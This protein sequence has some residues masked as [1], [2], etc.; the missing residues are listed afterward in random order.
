MTM[1]KLKNCFLIHSA[2]HPFY[3]ALFLF[4]FSFNLIGQEKSVSDS[5]KNDILAKYNGFETTPTNPLLQSKFDSLLIAL[6]IEQK[7]FFVTTEEPLFE[8]I[9]MIASNRNDYKAITIPNKPPSF[10]FNKTTSNFN[11]LNFLHAIG[12]HVNNDG[13]GN[14]IDL[15]EKELEANSFTGYFMNKMGYSKNTYTLYLKSDEKH[16]EPAIALNNIDQNLLNSAFKDGWETYAIEQ[17]LHVDEN[18]LE[19]YKANKKYVDSLILIAEK[20]FDTD[21]LVSANHYSKAYQYSNGK[22]ISTL[23]NAYDQFLKAKE[24]DKALLYANLLFKNSA[25]F[26]N[27]KSY[28]QLFNDIAMIYEIKRDYENALKFLDIAHTLDIKNTNLLDRKSLIISR[29]SN[30]EALINTL[31]ERIK[32]GS[33]STDL[34]YKLAGAYKAN[35]QPLEAIKYYKRIL[36]MSPKHI[37]ARLELAKLYIEEG[38]D[39]VNILNLTDLSKN[40]SLDI[41][42]SIKTKKT[43]WD[44]AKNVL[45]EGLKTNPKNPYLKQELKNLKTLKRTKPITLHYNF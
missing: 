1:I 2:K 37:N 34:Y 39:I 5:I 38:V 30:P 44:N 31:I 43:L 21:Y 28:K 33:V 23:Y 45:K 6:G 14:T 7:I 42:K 17:S 27:I 25:R 19:I 16:L 18:N 10:I 4:L 22:K 9:W 32:I 13:D 15:V 8:Y 11:A 12:H 40:P 35:K 3:C 26:L 36:A 24:L 41:K 20:N 29:Q